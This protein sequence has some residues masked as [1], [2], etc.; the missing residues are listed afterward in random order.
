MVASP[1]K[2]S[3]SGGAGAGDGGGVGL[4]PLSRAAS[5]GN[6]LRLPR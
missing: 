6:R 4:A 3:V 5:L 2:R 1:T